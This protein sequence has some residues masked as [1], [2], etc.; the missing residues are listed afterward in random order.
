MKLGILVP[1]R[2]RAD[3]LKK[4]I[5]G[6]SDYL[7]SY[8]IEFEI[9]IIHQLG[10]GPFNRGKLLNVGYLN[11]PNPDYFIFHDVD[12]FP[13]R[14]TKDTEPDH[15][16]YHGMPNYFPTDHARSIAKPAQKV[17]GCIVAVS[18]HALRDVNGHSNSYWGWGYEDMDF[19]Y[20]LRHAEIRIDEQ[21]KRSSKPYGRKWFKWLDKGSGWVDG[22]ER[23]QQLF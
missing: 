16:G 12:I 3:Q 1:Y 2:D 7:V 9:T 10:Q 21:G 13:I 17:A 8:D 19:Y 18:N 15:F 6:L 11:S 4:F 5:P 23:N 22:Y 20:R 14:G